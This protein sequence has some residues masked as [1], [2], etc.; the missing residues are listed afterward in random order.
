ML[1]KQHGARQAKQKERKKFVEQLVG[2]IGDKWSL[3]IIRK[4]TFGKNPGRFNELMRELSPISSRMLSAKLS[5]L[6]EEGI[7][8]KRSKTCISSVC[9]MF[10]D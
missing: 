9:F 6:V 3:L 5:K 1:V 7:I 4:P 8:K 2:I 10:A